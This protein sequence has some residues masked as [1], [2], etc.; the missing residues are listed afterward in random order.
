M[1]NIV[2]HVENLGKRYHIGPRQR[3]KALRDTLT[4]AL[5]APFRA[6]TSSPKSP[7][8]AS[9][10]PSSGRGP[11]DHIWALKD[12]SFDIKEGD[13]VAIIGRNG[14]GKTTLL[15]ILSRITRPT[16]G[17]A[18]IF[19][20]VGTLLEVGTGF[21]PELTGRENIYLNGAI[22]GM[23]RKEIERNFDEIVAFAEVEKFI[24]TPVKHYS[25]GMYVRLAFAVAAHLQTEILIVDE[26]LAVGDAAFQKK[27]LGKMGDVAKEGR[28]VLFVSHNM[29][30]IKMLCMKGIL[31]EN[32]R[33]HQ[34]GPIE[35]TVHEYNRKMIGE[36]RANASDP[37]PIRNQRHGI[38]INNCA[39]LVHQNSGGRSDLEIT[40]EIES[41]RRLRNIG[42]GLS[43][44]SMNGVQVSYLAP[45][46]TNY[47]INEVNGPC[48]CTFY[49]R[50][51]DKYLAGG[52]YIVGVWLSKPRTERLV[53]AERASL[54]CIPSRDVFS[55]GM[56]FEMR[57]FGIVPLPMKFS[58]SR[59][60]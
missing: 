57:R 14:A 30:A 46:V 12:V 54:V 51:V 1:S 53:K 44:T 52:E 25:S 42:V 7:A 23:R 4:D 22:L 28:T 58:V 17:Y 20:R 45:V 35:N 24:D 48:P 26:V 56:D 6:A 43:L 47:I 11:D 5:Y 9:V 32:G 55:T 2:F 19:G 40:L 60:H 13:V 16:E 50:N 8:F 15:K 39:A 21:H 33:I 18:R 49:C 37:F 36:A 10:L 34:V 41:D 31:L 59:S 27:C 3:Y 38:S 29:A